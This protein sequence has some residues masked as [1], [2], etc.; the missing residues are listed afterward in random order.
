[1][2]GIDGR[3]DGRVASYLGRVSSPPGGVDLDSALTHA[4]ARWMALATAEIREATSSAGR[5]FVVGNGGSFD[6]ARLIALLLQRSGVDARIPGSRGDYR[7][8]TA[9][10]GFSEI[11]AAALQ[12]ET[13][14]DAD[15]LIAISGSGNSINIIRAIE[16]ASASGAKILGLGGRDGGEMKRRIGREATFIAATD[17]MEAL[18][19]VHPLVMAAVTRMLSGADTDATEAI[20]SVRHEVIDPLISGPGFESL[21]QLAADVMT[22]IFEG[23]RI[24]VLGDPDLHPSV[25]HMDADWGRGMINQ[26]PIAGPV[27][28]SYT[29][30]NAWMATGNDD[31][32]EFWLIDEFAKASANGSDVVV[33][34]G[35]QSECRALHLC[36]EE[37]TR[38]GIAPYVIS[39]DESTGYVRK[40]PASSGTVDLVSTVVLHAVSRSVHDYIISDEGLAWH[41]EE[42]PI[43]RWPTDVV[44]S[45]RSALRGRKKLDRDS[46]ERLETTLRTRGLLRGDQVITWCYGV[47]HVAD[48]PG[49]FGLERGFY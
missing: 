41:V 14:G 8:V 23:G 48:H 6:N 22:T 25:T 37:C 45:L 24:F 30:E 42:A 46:T 29:N 47:P 7:R 34:I 10:T 2:A 21:A 43:D 18:E 32:A 17:C 49:K 40:I 36:L 38:A 3:L 19:D 20:E 31:G 1:M 44:T 33:A 27:R 11:F 39:E 9:H 13:I 26:L 16:H 28:V 35:A 5:V 15:L 4:D 12:E